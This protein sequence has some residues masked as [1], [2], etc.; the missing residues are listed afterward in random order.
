MRPRA[1]DERWTSAMLL[2]LLTIPAAAPQVPGVAEAAVYRAALTAMTFES[3]GSASRRHLLI[4]STTDPGGLWR[5]LD[6]AT[7]ESAPYLDP[8][9]RL[10]YARPDAV[11]AFL[12]A[13]DVQRPL[14]QELRSLPDFL[15][16]E[17]SE[18]QTLVARGQLKAFERRHALAPGSVAVSRI[19]FDAS[20][21][22]ALLYVSFSCGSLCG[23]G[24]FVLLERGAGGWKVLKM[25]EYMVS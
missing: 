6:K 9:H 18:L 25:D 7:I 20:G 19:G 15:I 17:Q 16:V 4:A 11:E 14:P 8:R 3:L 21:S 12:Q 5:G 2:V 24:T 10:K 23:S 22:Q 13:I 1:L